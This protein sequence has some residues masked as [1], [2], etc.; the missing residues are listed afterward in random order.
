MANNCLHFGDLDLIFK[1]TAVVK[2]KILR[3]FLPLIWLFFFSDFFSNYILQGGGRY[4][5]F[6]ADPICISISIGLRVD[7]TIS[8]EPVLGFLPNFHG[9]IIGMYKR[10]TD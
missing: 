9:Y 6:G 8:C 2:L 5:V 4:T 1:V 3:H 10:R 7:I